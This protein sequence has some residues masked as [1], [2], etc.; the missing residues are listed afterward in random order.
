MELLSVWK[1]QSLNKRVQIIVSKNN[2][3][4]SLKIVKPHK[5]HDNKK[6]YML[7]NY[8]MR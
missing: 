7:H 5:N 2:T 1:N 3:F 6:N 4:K 8:K